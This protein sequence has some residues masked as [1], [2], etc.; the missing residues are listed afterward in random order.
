MLVPFATHLGWLVVAAPGGRNARPD[1]LDR[2]KV[3]SL[4]Q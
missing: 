3:G 1:R 2:A 4:R